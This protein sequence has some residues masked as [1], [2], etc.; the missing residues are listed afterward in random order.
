MN[1]AVMESLALLVSIMLLVIF[2][3]GFIAFGLSWFRS[4]W[5]RIATYVFAAF[6]ILSGLWL[7]VTLIDGNGLAV[8]FLPVALGAFSIFNTRRKAK[9]K[10]KA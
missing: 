9:A 8:G 1:G 4:Q 5:A 3:A 10:P 6:S 2:G 7:A